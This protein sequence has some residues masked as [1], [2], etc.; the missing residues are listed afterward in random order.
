LIREIDPFHCEQ[1]KHFKNLASQR[2]FV[3]LFLPHRWGVEGVGCSRALE[4]PL[5]VQKPSRWADLSKERNYRPKSG[6]AKVTSKLIGLGLI[7][8]GIQAMGLAESY[9]CIV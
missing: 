6:T 1:T 9:E 8:E 3:S 4:I 7:Y 5:I 2:L